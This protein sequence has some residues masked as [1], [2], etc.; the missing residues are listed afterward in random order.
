MA[1]RVHTLRYVE[2]RTASTFLFFFTT[3]FKTSG[4]E[5]IFEV[6]SNSGREKYAFEVASQPAVNVTA[7]VLE[8]ADNA[9]N[10]LFSP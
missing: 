5:N 6:V 3:G 10:C 9:T 1:T 2:E 8:Q 7:G 4:L